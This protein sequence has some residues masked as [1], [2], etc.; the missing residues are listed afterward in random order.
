[1]CRLVA[2]FVILVS[3]PFFAFNSFDASAVDDGNQYVGT[4][5]CRPCHQHVQH[6]QYKIWSE[7]AHAAAFKTL[8]TDNAKDVAAKSGVNGPPE[9]AE[10]CLKCHA[11]GYNLDAK[12]LGKKFGVEDGVQCET[13]HSA[14]SEYK[15]LQTMKNHAKSVAAGM[16]DLSA[17][18]AVEKLCAE[19]HNEKSP[20]YTGFAFAQRW[21]E[22]E[23][24]YPDRK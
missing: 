15:K 14:G 1:M 2:P 19:C 4:T 6:N 17:E 13:C 16:A 22:I 5:S 18:G 21:A 20:N 12:R 24:N 9:K 11:T 10:A 8:K 7:S 3:L 23:H